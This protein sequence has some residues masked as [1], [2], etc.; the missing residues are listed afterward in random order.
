MTRVSPRTRLSVQHLAHSHC[1]SGIALA[2][3]VTDATAATAAAAG[4]TVA[5]AVTTR[6]V[7]MIG[8]GNLTCPRKVASLATAAADAAASDVSGHGV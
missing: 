5:A 6:H 4:A 7:I 1:T 2:S 8:T 3:T